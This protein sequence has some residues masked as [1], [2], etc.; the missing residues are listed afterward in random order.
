MAD[1]DVTKVDV[2]GTSPLHFATLNANDDMVNTLIEAGAQVRCW[3]LDTFRAPCWCVFS[4][5]PPLCN[6]RSTCATSME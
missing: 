3:Q 2:D 5:T 6:W 1:A 4:L